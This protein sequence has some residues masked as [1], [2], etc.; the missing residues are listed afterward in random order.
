MRH[1]TSAYVDKPLKCVQAE[2]VE[3]SKCAV[4]TRPH[5][6][7]KVSTSFRG[8]FIKTENDHETNHHYD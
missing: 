3:L 2:V 8:R 6:L 7:S 5:E 4:L 1:N